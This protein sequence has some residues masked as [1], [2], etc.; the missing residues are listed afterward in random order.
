[1][2]KYPTR[3]G[4]SKSAAPK[5][6]RADKESIAIE[7]D[8][9]EF[10]HAIGNSELQK[11]KKP[12]VYNILE[13]ENASKFLMGE[14]RKVY[15]GG[16]NQILIAS[17]TRDYDSNKAALILNRT[18]M[19]K[20][21][22]VE[23]FGDTPVV[24]NGIKS[25]GSI[26]SPPV[27]KVVGKYWA[28]PDGS[29]WS[30]ETQEPT[31]AQIDAQNL[32]EKKIKRPVFSTFPVWSA[33]DIHHL[34]PDQYKEKLEELVEIRKG[35][36]YEFNPEDQ[37]ETLVLN[38]ID[39]TIKRQGIES[40]QGGNRAYYVP[41]LDSMNTPEQHQFVNPI[42]MYA[43]TMHELAHSTKHITGR[44]AQSKDNKEY[45]IEEIVAETTA[46]MMVKQ[47]ENKLSDVIETRPDI[48]LMFQEY[49]MNAMS[50]NHGWGEEFQFGELVSR[51]EAERENDK[52]LI[53]TI[54]VNIAK[55]V[56]TLT[57]GE[58]TP[59]QRLEFKNKSFE[60]HAKKTNSLEPSL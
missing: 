55:A 48:Q 16:Y 34:L 6:T 38:I 43:V 53:K 25:I 23:E 24:K 45:A 7:N 32:T 58:F 47:L 30:G 36:G 54:M 10:W 8:I 2:A 29:R 42:A 22:G 14:E 44:N 52:S 31:K 59:E 9:I 5:E 12:W 26:F 60:R 13:A 37:V 17:Y 49:Y 51:L 19:S 41:A 20:I 28:R 3:K 27:E 57:N 21:F 15:R 4:K 33:H 35:K 40:T 46:V 39:E 11:W 1:M 18:D 50:Y 56:D